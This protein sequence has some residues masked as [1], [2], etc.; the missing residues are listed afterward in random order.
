MDG[1]CSRIHLTTKPAGWRGSTYTIG[2][3]PALAPGLPHNISFLMKTKMDFRNHADILFVCLF[4]MEPSERFCVLCVQKRNKAALVQSLVRRVPGTETSSRL[5]WISAWAPRP[6]QAAAAP[7]G[8]AREAVS[9]ARL[10]L[11]VVVHV[12]IGIKER[13]SSEIRVWGSGK[14]VLCSLVLEGLC[15]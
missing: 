7:A 8:R 4:A 15:P 14:A 9:L 13:V 12:H 2:G 10:V 3:K 11:C 6:T 5:R 1:G